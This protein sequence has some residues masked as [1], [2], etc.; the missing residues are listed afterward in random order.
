MDPATPVAFES[1]IAHREWVRRLAR[2]LVLDE[3]RAADLEQ[4][5]WL[6]ALVR[7]PREGRSPRGWLATA[8]RHNAIDESRVDSRRAARER[9]AARREAEPSSAELVAEADALQ[10]VVRAVLDL[11]EPYRSTLLRRFFEDLGPTAIAEREGVSVETVRTRLR[12]GLDLVRARFDREHEGD[13]RAWCLLMVPLARRAGPLESAGA[14]AA[15]SAAG[16]LALLSSKA[17]IAGA[18]LAVAGLGMWAWSAS[19]VPPV[20]APPPEGPA[21]VAAAKAPAPPPAPVPAAT[22]PAPEPERGM[23]VEV[24]VRDSA[25][26]PVPDAAVALL[27]GND[28]EGLPFFPTD[29]RELSLAPPS[30]RESRRTDAEGR[31]IFEALPAGDWSLVAT[32]RDGAS[33]PTR[34]R[35]TLGGAPPPLRLLLLPAHTVEGRILRADGKPIEGV[36]L[37]LRPTGGRGM[38][39][40]E[41]A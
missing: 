5:V 32:A 22:A 29:A 26:R 16:L 2:S 27:E 13:R 15:G 18:V 34:V 11:D 30:P 20:P 31:A 19:G 4:E 35:S 12:R 40:S 41:A 33:R 1:L 36:L 23:R 3:A 21:G 39:D 8:L 24:L 38:K 28:R 7:P 25:D 37:S 17:A 14:A 6:E 9:A 10:R